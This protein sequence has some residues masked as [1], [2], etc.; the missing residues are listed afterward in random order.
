MKYSKDMWDMPIHIDIQSGRNADRDVEE[1]FAYFEHINEV[2]ST[3]LATSE[4]SRINRGELSFASSSEEMKEV[5]ALCEQTKNETRGYFDH[6]RNGYCDPLGVVKGWAV[7]NAADTLMNKG[8]KNFYINAG[9]DVVVRGAKADGVAWSVGI[10]NPFNQ[11]EIVKSIYLS[12]KSIATSGTYIR[13][14][15]IIDPHEPTKK[16]TDVVSVS[17]IGPNLCDADRFATAAFAMGTRGI[18]FIESL[19]GF[20]GYEIL[21]NGKGVETSGLS[22]YY[23]A[24]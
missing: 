19:E 8:Y 9:G 17:V 23:E 22:T 11:H 13:G 14:Q 7:Q 16:L 15:H 10:K 4:I 12:D 18:M 24:D 1:I 6:I 3:F 5:L 20:E 2:F 21:S